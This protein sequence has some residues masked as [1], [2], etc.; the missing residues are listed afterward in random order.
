MKLSVTERTGES[1]LIPLRRWLT[2]LGVSKVTAWRWR[3]RG[4]IRLIS[5]AG[6]NYIARSEIRNFEDRAAA[7]EFRKVASI[8]TS[9]QRESLH[10]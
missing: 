6:R 3:K 4:Y 8:Q 2:E 7:G 1:G 9:N 10:H 5:I